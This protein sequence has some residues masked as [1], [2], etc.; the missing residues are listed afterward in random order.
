MIILGHSVTIVTSA[1]IFCVPS[2]GALQQSVGEIQ[3]LFGEGEHPTSAS[4]RLCG[5]C[6]AYGGDEGGGE[7]DVQTNHT[8]MTL[9]P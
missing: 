2:Q 1:F 4:E 5:L 6:A 3:G 8:G 7:N 9:L